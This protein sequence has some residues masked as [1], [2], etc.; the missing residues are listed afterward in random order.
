MSLYAYQEAGIEFLAKRKRAFLA[1]EMGLGK[2]VQA[3]RACDIVGAGHVLVICPAAARTNWAREFRT[4]SPA[5]TVQTIESSK[6]DANAEGVVITSFDLAVRKEGTFSD[7]VFDVVIIDEAHFLKN[8]KSKRTNAI[9]GTGCKGKD[10]IISH[11]KR[12][13]AMSGT[14]VPNNYSELWTLIRA[15]VPGLIDVKGKPATYTQFVK[16][17]CVIAQTPFA[18]M[19]IIGSK[20][21]AD[22]RARL[23]GC[24][25]RRKKAEVLHD[26]PP[27]RYATVSL[28]PDDARALSELESK[29]AVDLDAVL[30]NAEAGWQGRGCPMHLASM[31]RITGELKA[32]PLVEL[33]AS[34][35]AD[36]KHKIVVFAH[37]T[38]VIDILAKGLAL[39]GAVVLDGRTPYVKRQQNIDLFDT[40]DSVRVF[41]G[42][43]TAAGTAINLTAASN[44][45]F[46]EAS[47]APGDNA[48]AAMRC[49][50]IGQKSSVLVRFA[51]L[52]GSVDEK[53]TE[54]LRRKTAEISLLID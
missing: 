32:R 39:Y 7:H 11:A 49:H 38:S 36:T 17:Y 33:L 14:F 40:S 20:N 5:R 42:Q 4:W 34:E 53:V 41:I 43:I 45:V 27:I 25:L 21:A 37:H 8:R 15:L 54:V 9:L 47:W 46:A 52:D 28:H 31:R 22:L 23:K 44:V 10:G 1:D 16:H 3:I 12:V 48:Q 51:S 13:W 19:K 29:H 24:Y 26:L 35:L 6:D 30:A 18:Q 2:T 50:R